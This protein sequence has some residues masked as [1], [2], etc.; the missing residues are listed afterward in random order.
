MDTD[1]M[2]KQTLMW[3]NTVPRDKLNKN[4]MVMVIRNGIATFV[5]KHLSDM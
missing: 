2:K 1:Q 3:M 4:K 5:P